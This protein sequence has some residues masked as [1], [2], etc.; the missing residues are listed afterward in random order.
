MTFPSLYG[1]APCLDFANTFDARALPPAEE[2]IPTYPDLARWA[3]F[4]GLLA[5]PEALAQQAA[6]HPEEAAASY[7]TAIDLREAIFRVFTEPTEA[8]ADLALLQRGYATAMTAAQLQHAG[9]GFTWTYPET[10][11]DAPWWP[12]AQNAMEL[13]TTGDLT[14]VK[15]CAFE[16]GCTG[17]FLDTSKNGSR[18]W[19]SM[20]DCGTEAKI[21]RQTAR[22]REV[23]TRSAGS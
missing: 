13:L 23:R 6:E 17:L 21:Q 1:G 16:E 9:T 8:A 14:R 7:Q 12:I 22:R 5:A 19:C 10:H 18:R 20:E 2:H 15:L 11:L 4:A 3:T